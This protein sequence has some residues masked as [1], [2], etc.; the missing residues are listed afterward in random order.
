MS[1]SSASARSD[2]DARGELDD[3]QRCLG[4][5]GDAQRGDHREHRDRR[6]QDRRADPVRGRETRGVRAGEGRRGRRARCVPRRSGRSRPAARRLASPSRGGRG[7]ANILRRPPAHQQAY[8]RHP[9]REVQPQR[10][11]RDAQHRQPGDGR[12]LEEH[13]ADD[14]EQRVERED[15]GPLRP[16]PVACPARRRARRRAA[17]VASHSAA[18]RSASVQGPRAA[19]PARA[20]TVSIA[21]IAAR[22]S[23]RRRRPAPARARSRPWQ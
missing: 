7:R 14:G 15:P 16:H 20:R 12:A 4:A 10:H 13:A 3:A 5:E 21:S 23:Q 19:K 22:S 6:E 8:D 17:C 9:A 11:E 18:R 1:S 2:H